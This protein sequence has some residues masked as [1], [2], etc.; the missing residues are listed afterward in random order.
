MQADVKGP[1]GTSRAGLV[2]DTGSEMTTLTHK[3]AE[4]LGYSPRDGLRLTTSGLL[5]AEPDGYV[6]RIAQLDTLQLSAKDLEVS[7]VD[8]DFPGIGGVL[9]M[10]FL[11]ELNFE[12]RAREQ[13][14]IVESYVH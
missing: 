10:N 4:S 5:R 9:G 3:L 11:G 14:I 2:L 12:V 6:L 13:K 8:L 7:V 1:R